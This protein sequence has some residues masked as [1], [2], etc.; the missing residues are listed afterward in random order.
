M[1]SN[2]L[3]TVLSVMILALFC[4]SSIG[5]SFAAEDSVKLTGSF[6]FIGAIRN[7]TK[8]DDITNDKS[9]KK[10]YAFDSFSSILLDA[11]TKTDNDIVY[12]LRLSLGL[13]SL[14]DGSST[15]NGSHIFISKDEIGKLELG[16]PYPASVKMGIQFLLKLFCGIIMHY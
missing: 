9:I 5:N 4:F 2:F 6:N 12:G 14:Q 10:R 3:K 7:Q 15:I 8:I 11:Q 13:S 16:S 1:Y